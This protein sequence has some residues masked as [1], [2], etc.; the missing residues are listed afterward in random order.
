MKALDL[1]RESMKRRAFRLRYQIDHIKNKK[2]RQKVIAEY[3][4]LIK[5]ISPNN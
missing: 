4:S 2:A 5:Q 3:V 1:T